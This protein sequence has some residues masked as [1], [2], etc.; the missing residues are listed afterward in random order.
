MLQNYSKHTLLLHRLLRQ[1]VFWQRKQKAGES[2]QQYVADL[3]SLAVFCKFG[4]ME[5]EMIRDQ[6]AEH[7]THPKMC[8]KLP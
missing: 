7:A 3:R 5:E 8:V 6:L 4:D 2:V 1:I